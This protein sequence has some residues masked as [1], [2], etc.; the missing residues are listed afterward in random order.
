[1]IQ[2]SDGNFYGTSANG[3]F[4]NQGTLFEVTPGGLET[5]LYYF[6]GGPDGRNPGGLIQGIDGIFYGT[7]T[8]GGSSNLG[9]VFAF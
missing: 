2:G 9:T 7:T 3:G 6:S 5:V 4:D 1:L 8:N